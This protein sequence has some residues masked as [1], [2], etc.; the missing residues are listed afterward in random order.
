MIA[1]TETVNN[2]SEQQST[3]SQNNQLPHLTYATVVANMANISEYN[4]NSQHQFQNSA[5]SLF[6]R[7]QS[8]VLN[9][10][11]NDT[12]NELA[13]LS[14]SSVDLLQTPTLQNHAN[15]NLKRELDIQQQQQQHQLKSNSNNMQELNVLRANLIQCLLPAPDKT[16]PETTSS[17]VVSTPPIQLDSTIS[18]QPNNAPT[19]MSTNSIPNLN[20]INSSMQSTQLN[21]S[22]L[23]YTFDLKCNVCKSQLLGI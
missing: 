5:Q 14:L 23:R 13:D 16:I 4:A 20:L 15:L 10:S 9:D 19:N 22:N 21:E 18:F 3:L 12:V 2:S 8:I 17:L 11:M 6:N 1:T 7:K